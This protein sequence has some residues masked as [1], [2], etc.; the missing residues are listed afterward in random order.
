[1]SAYEAPATA[2][3]VGIN[4]MQGTYNGAELS[5]A[6]ARAARDTREIPTRIGARLHYR[7]GRVTDLDGH[8]VSDSAKTPAKPADPADMGNPITDL[9]GHPVSAPQRPYKPRQGSAPARVLAS[10][11]SEGAAPQSAYITAD[12]VLAFFGVKYSDWSSIFGPA[13]KGGALKKIRVHGK[14]ALALPD[15]IETG[16]A[17][18]ESPARLAF[19]PAQPA[20]PT[21]PIVASPPAQPTQRAQA[22][23]PRPPELTTA[24]AELAEAAERIS[25]VLAATFEEINRIV[26]EA[27]TH[28]KAAS[29]QATGSAHV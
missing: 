2:R 12:E 15:Y 11:R 26:R 8:P 10:L 1:M 17:E 16:L 27:N 4:P 24:M 6:P 25:H 20:P 28:I 14:P 9:D 29:A 18:A 19:L 22:P 23:Q 5:R 21:R 7:D 3:A 13:V